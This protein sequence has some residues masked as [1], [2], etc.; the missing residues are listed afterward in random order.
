MVKKGGGGKS[1]EELALEKKMELERRLQ[2]VSGQLMNSAKKPQKPKGRAD[3]SFWSTLQFALLCLG[4]QETT[5][6]P[7][8]WP[9]AGVIEVQAFMGSIYFV[10]RV[11]VEQ[12]GNNR[13]ST[14]ETVHT[15]WDL[16]LNNY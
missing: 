14:G 11:D 2:D 7:V 15:E 16:M 4:V 8:W 1:R 5:I 12:A 6:S 13:A 10:Y 9:Q 3:S